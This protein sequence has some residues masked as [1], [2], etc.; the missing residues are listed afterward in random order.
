[1]AAD[2]P[3]ALLLSQTHFPKS[4][5]DVGLRCKLLDANHRARFDMRERAGY[6]IGAA[7]RGCWL[8]LI[9]FFQCSEASSVAWQAQGSFCQD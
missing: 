6:R 9:R 4:I 5:D 7:F 3:D 8:S 1:M 2:E